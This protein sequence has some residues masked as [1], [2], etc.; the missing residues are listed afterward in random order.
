MW[1]SEFRCFYYQSFIALFRFSASLGAMETGCV[2]ASGAVLE[3]QFELDK[4]PVVTMGCLPHYPPT[5]VVYIHRMAT[6]TFAILCL[7]HH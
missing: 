4:F 3:I 1:L 7:G 2:C 6:L 5:Q